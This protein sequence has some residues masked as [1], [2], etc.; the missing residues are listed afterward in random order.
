MPIRKPL[1]THSPLAIKQDKMFY[2][3]TYKAILSRI[4]IYFVDANKI[5]QEIEIPWKDDKRTFELFQGCHK[6][7]FYEI[8]MFMVN[9]ASN[10][11]NNN[12]GDI[13]DL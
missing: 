2:Y 12:A 13:W 11:T 8:Q 7:L 4:I 1:Y 3:D 5:P 9:N 10:I 6:R